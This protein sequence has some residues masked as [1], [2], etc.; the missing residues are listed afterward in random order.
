MPCV[1]RDQHQDEAEQHKIACRIGDG[2][3]DGHR[4][5]PDVAEER[6]QDDCCAERA[7]C[8]R[9]ERAIQPNARVERC[10]PGTQS[11]DQ[12]R[13]NQWVEGEPACVSQ[14][15]VRLRT[16]ILN[17]E[18]VDGEANEPPQQPAP[19]K[20]PLHTG[21]PNTGGAQEAQRRCDSEGRD[22]DA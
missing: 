8:E 3:Q 17:I 10:Q 18:V 21:I 12:R 1:C 22:V 11:R 13:I 4:H 6:W 2:G 14:T 9:P 7:E 16:L 5:A 20:E 15:R 19:E